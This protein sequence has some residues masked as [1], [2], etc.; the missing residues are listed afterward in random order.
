MTGNGCR[1]PSAWVHN[2]EQDTMKALIQATAL[3]GAILAAG[4]HAQTDTPA[5]TTTFNIAATTDYRYRG[6]S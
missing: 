4:A 6:I 5:T 2:N 3:A 1:I